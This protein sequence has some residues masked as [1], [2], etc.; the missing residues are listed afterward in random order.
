MNS[1][2]T[3]IRRLLA[4]RRR[5]AQRRVDRERARKGHATRIHKAF[6]NDRLL[7]EMR[8]ANPQSPLASSTQ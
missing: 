5:K 6:Q 3:A 7:N 1:P 2:I 8:R 4:Q